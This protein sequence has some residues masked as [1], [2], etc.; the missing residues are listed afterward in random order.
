VRRRLVLNKMKHKLPKGFDIYIANPDVYNKRRQDPA[1]YTRE[2]CYIVATITYKDHEFSVMCN[3]EM[4]I[5]HHDGTIIRYTEDLDRL[6]ITT[7]KKLYAIPEEYCINNSW[8]EI[9][10]EVDE[11]CWDGWIAHTVSD[12]ISMCVEAIQIKEMEITNA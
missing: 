4:R 5:E 10:D 8:F 11:D 12:A 3:G 7:D 1:F 6:G 9:W 2:P